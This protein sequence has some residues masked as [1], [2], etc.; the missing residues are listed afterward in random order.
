MN[1]P[2]NPTTTPTPGAP[3]PVPA[4][5]PD[6]DG[7]GL[8]DDIE[9][10]LGTNPHDD[11]TDGDRFKDGEEVANPFL[12]PRVRGAADADP[13]LAKGL[14]QSAR[15]WEARQGLEHNA[16]TD[17]DGFAD[18]VEMVSLK[19]VPNPTA[20]DVTWNRSPLDEFMH[21]AQRYTGKPYRFGAEVDP[22]RSEPVEVTALDSGELVELAAKRAGVRDMPDGTWKQYQFL[23]DQGATVS[24]EEALNTK[25]ALVF[26]FTSDPLA[27]GTIPDGRYVAISM[28]D[29]KNVLE[30]SERTGQV[31][32]VPH[33]G[34]YKYAATIPALHAP[35]GDLDGDG[36]SDQ[37]E[38]MAGDDVSRSIRTPMSATEMLPYD[39]SGTNAADASAAARDG[40]PLGSDRYATADTAGMSRDDDPYAG[41]EADP[42]AGLA[43]GDTG[44]GARSYGP[45][46]E[47]P[48]GDSAGG[49][50][51]L[52]SGDAYAAAGA[53]A[54]ADPRDAYGD[55]Y[56]DSSYGDSYGDSGGGAD[57]DDSYDSS[58]YG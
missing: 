30:V 43:Y 50:S 51:A 54:G 41:T 14:E 11:D 55:S 20:D 26:G 19:N 8:R 40:D 5:I 37:E 39:G 7:D 13:F 33:D 10:D 53:G 57:D 45:S 47:D 31:R 44:V 49:S 48:Y 36:W 15:D 2:T 35:T 9:R 58:T 29:G 3:G 21:Q 27:Q 28:G 22:A 6:S 12:N 16:D 42:R 46:A 18:W 38:L 17:G 1:D 34:H 52:T 25:G 24:V 56:G 32:V 4:P 23:H